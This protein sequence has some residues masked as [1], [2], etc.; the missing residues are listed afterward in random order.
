MPGHRQH[1]KEMLL[2]LSLQLDVSA[3]LRPYSADADS[4]L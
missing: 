2:S 1:S 4:A 3:M